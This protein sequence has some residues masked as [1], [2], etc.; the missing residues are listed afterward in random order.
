MFAPLWLSILLAQEPQ[1]LPEPVLLDRIAVIVG[2]RLVM[3]SELRLEA[4]LQGHGVYTLDALEP[5][6]TDTRAWLV[7]IAVVRGL[8]GDVSVYQP[9]ADDV[10][11]RLS[12]VRETWEDPDAFE[13]FLSRHGLELDDLAAL[14]VTRMV[15][16]RYIQ[17]NIGVAVDQRA[18]DAA[19]R[20]AAEY[21]EWITTRRQSVT[22]RP[23]QARQQ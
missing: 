15:V 6:R 9:G 5:R 12:A 23:V 18:P 16:E 7:D 19:Q 10:Q 14:L 3:A 21:L 17:R 1:A 8:A 2:D 22:I 20:F 11:A 4:E 13:A